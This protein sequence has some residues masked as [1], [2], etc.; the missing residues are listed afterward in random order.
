MRN[1]VIKDISVIFLGAS[2]TACERVIDLDLPKGQEL[3]YVDAWIT[4]QPGVQTIK[5]LKATDYM[6]SAAPEAVSDAQISVTDVTAGKSYPFTYKNGAY[7][8]DAGSNAIGVVGHTYKL[9]I[10]WKGEQ[11]EATDELK[12]NTR[13]DSLTS[14]FEEADGEDKEGFY[15]KLYVH[16]V[17]GAVDY[18][19]IRTYRNGTL[20]Y[21]VGE[22]LSADGSFGDDGL[23]DGYAFIPPFRDGVTAG[24]KPYEKGDNVKVL[25]RSLSKGSHE[26]LEQVQSQLANDGLFGRVMHNVPSNLNNLSSTGKSKIYG[27]FGAVAEISASIKVE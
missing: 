3:P 10:T 17:V 22:M 21:H 2:F 23:T 16:D 24:E 18:Y 7:N 20:N 11:F 9:N 15:V 14:E 12:R 19:W 25:I 1:K 26:F 13:I 8:Y 5:F 6:S 4:D 27:W